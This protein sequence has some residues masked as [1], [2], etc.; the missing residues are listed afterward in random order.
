[1][2]RKPHRF[3]AGFNNLLHLMWTVFLSQ[4]EKCGSHSSHYMASTKGPQD[5]VNLPIAM[6]LLSMLHPL[7]NSCYPGFNKD[8]RNGHS[9]LASATSEVQEGGCKYTN[10]LCS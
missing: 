7:S 8:A 5:S 3:A 1:M 2:G 4:K 10:D 9:I 6:S